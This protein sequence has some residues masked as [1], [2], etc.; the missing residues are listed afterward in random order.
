MPKLPVLKG[1]EILNALTSDKGGFFVHHQRGSHARLRHRVKKNLRVT[2]PVH[3]K[4]VP[5]IT[6]PGFLSRLP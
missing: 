4:D 5:E 3:T 6:L 1:K 2:I